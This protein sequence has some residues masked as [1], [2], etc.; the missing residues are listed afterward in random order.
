MKTHPYYAPTPRGLANVLL[1]ELAALGVGGG[2]EQ[3]AGVGFTGPL[4]TAYR[5]VLGSRVASR[6]LLVL[7][8]FSAPTPEALYNGA[9]ALAWEELFSP[10]DTFRVDAVTA[11]SG[12]THSQYAALKVKDAVADRFR[13]ACGRRPNVDTAAPGVGIHLHLN[14]DR[15]TLSL[16]L[17]G[18]GLHRR[19][20]RVQTV[21]APLKENLAAAILRLAGWPDIAAAGGG[22]ADPLCGSGTFLIE[23][24][25]MAGDSAPGLTRG[26]YGSPAWKGHD[27]GLWERLLEEARTRA[28]AGRS[29]IPQVAGADADPVAVAAARGNIRAAGLT[30]LVHARPQALGAGGPLVDT[31]VPGLVVVNPPYGERLGDVLELEDLY[32]TLGRVLLEQYE[33]FSASV[34]TGNPDLGRHMGLRASKSHSLFNGPIPV[35]LLHFRVEAA[36]RMR[37]AK[38]PAPAPG[39]EMFANRMRKNLKALEKWAKKQGVTCFRAYDAD[40]PEYNLSVDM[41]QGDRTRAHVLEYPPP[42]SVDPG[43]ARARLAEALAAL[44]GV[45]GIPREDV[46][47]KERLGGHKKVARELSPTGEFFEA[48][49]GP[50]R[51]LVNFTDFLDTGLPL[52]LRLVRQMARDLAP[53]K[54][55]LSLFGGN[56]AFAVVMIAG[57]AA[58]C[59]MVESSGRYL[60]WAR[61][62]LAANRADPGRH[63]LEKE[64]PVQWLETRGASPSQAGQ[65]G[66]VVMEPPTRLP[67]LDNPA[68]A[69]LT[70]AHARLALA[71]AG[72]LAPGGTLL[73]VTRSPRP[74]VA[75]AA[76]A[77]F[78]TED[79]SART[80]PRDFRK[81]LR[82]HRCLAVRREP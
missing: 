15:A 66:L 33:G 26:G 36:R 19:G 7:A 29:R 72:L 21:R 18:Q 27:P 82:V 2:A 20:Y 35:K 5:A 65:Y 32:R 79:I 59:R 68:Q 75:P 69:N 49:E 8:D 76:L 62:N 42:A 63:P 48:A 70:A 56:G 14:R 57:G 4:E 10:D 24:A 78:R 53:E 64:D 81:S 22:L 38:A 3:G 46:V 12:I 55:C 37:P 40:M 43:K 1:S 44:P 41:Y 34:L 58:S 52:D 54:K 9:S 16:D 67:G 39:A 61:R 50:C 80:L 6:V 13:S 60:D 23:G 73:L 71:A 28:E 45:L 11:R 47:F 77:E 30:G 17:A 74:L 51:F 31:A 25:L